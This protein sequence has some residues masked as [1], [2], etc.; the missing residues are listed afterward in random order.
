MCR[1][2]QVRC[3]FVSGVPGSLGPVCDCDDAPGQTPSRERAYEAH[4]HGA[5][6]FRPDEAVFRR[7]YRLRTVYRAPR[8]PVAPSVPRA[9][10]RWRAS[11]S[12][13]LHKLFVAGRLARRVVDAPALFYSRP[14]PVLFVKCWRRRRRRTGSVVCWTPPPTRI[15]E[16][17]SAR[18][19]VIGF[20]SRA[21]PA[22]VTR[23]G[24]L[25]LKVTRRAP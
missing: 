19:V 9:A 17:T 15:A 12:G 23:G 1:G 21:R 24:C 22:R 16:K 4:V 3:E 13:R 25:P 8:G 5:D 18:A 7:R 6:V 10:R 14:G 20:S 11:R 2:R